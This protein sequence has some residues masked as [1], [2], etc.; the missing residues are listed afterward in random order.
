MFPTLR[1]GSSGSDVVK[2]QRYLNEHGN[3]VE[4]DG[5]FGPKTEAAVFEFQAAYHLQMDG[6]VGP[7][8]WGKLVEKEPADLDL[9][10]REMKT[11]HLHAL[12]EA[13]YLGIE[14]LGNFPTDMADDAVVRV[15]AVLEAA[16]DKYGM[17][18][19]P[20]GS[21]GG[22]QIACIVDEDGDGKPPSA[23]W[24]YWKVADEGLLKTMPAWCCIFVSWALRT[25]LSALKGRKLAWSE[26]PFGKWFG[27]CSSHLEPWARTRGDYLTAK[28][29]DRIVPGMIFT[30]GPD[31]VHPEANNPR[32]AAHTGFVLEVHDD[33][34]FTSIEGNAGDRV[35]SYRRKISSV[36]MF[37]PW[38]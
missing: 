30:L 11:K 35:N 25:G 9:S 23:Y 37:I 24:L 31:W 21:N 38:W 2:L 29:G 12:V 27:G 3:H 4:E 14:G 26:I 33:G 22:P 8:T 5:Q 28:D 18:E 1:R 15:V 13:H 19:V 20:R 6:I 16:V 10:W 17:M 7:K 32:A 36:R 34:T